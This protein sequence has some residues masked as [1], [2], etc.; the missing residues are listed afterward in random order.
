MVLTKGMTWKRRPPQGSLFN[1]NRQLALAFSLASCG[2]PAPATRARVLS[3]SNRR[4]FRRTWLML[5]LKGRTAAFCLDCHKKKLSLAPF[6]Q[7]RLSNP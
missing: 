5:A 1:V 4:G 7:K 2:L 6:G 3:L